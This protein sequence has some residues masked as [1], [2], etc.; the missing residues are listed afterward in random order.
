MSNFLVLQ[1]HIYHGMVEDQ[2]NMDKQY[3]TIPILRTRMVMFLN[4]IAVVG[5]SCV[6]FLKNRYTNDTIMSLEDFETFKQEYLK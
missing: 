2:R 3:S 5:D 1:E 4:V 6:E